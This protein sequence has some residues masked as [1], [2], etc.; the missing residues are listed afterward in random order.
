MFWNVASA[1]DVISLR[2]RSG[3]F[4]HLRTFRGGLV[5]DDGFC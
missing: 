2:K 1:L 4:A 3:S 5:A